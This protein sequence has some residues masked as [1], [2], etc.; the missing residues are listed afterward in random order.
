MLLALN[1]ILVCYV[2][3]ARAMPR[4]TARKVASTWCLAERTRFFRG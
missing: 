1:A 4:W 3:L 2:W